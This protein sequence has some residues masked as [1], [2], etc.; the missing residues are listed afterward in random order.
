LSGVKEQQAHARE[1]AKQAAAV[2]EMHLSK[3][4]MYFWIEI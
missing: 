1:S 2:Y 4:D 3:E